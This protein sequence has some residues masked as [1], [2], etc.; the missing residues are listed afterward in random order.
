MR[1]CGRQALELQDWGNCR[2]SS[3]WWRDSLSQTRVTVLGV[4]LPVIPKSGCR[5]LAS[6]RPTGSPAASGRGS[7]WGWGSSPTHPER[8]LCRKGGWRGSV[9]LLGNLAWPSGPPAGP[10]A[11]AGRPW[12]LLGGPGQAGCLCCMSLSG[13]EVPGAADHS[14]GPC[15]H[16]SGLAWEPSPTGA[17][18]PHVGEEGGR[19]VGERRVRPR[20]PS[21][22]AGPGRPGVDPWVLRPVEPPARQGFGGGRSARKGSCYVRDQPE[23]APPSLTPSCP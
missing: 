9:Y 7:D 11:R 18:N 5:G 23:A 1:V 8:R 19:V 15:T 16:Q 22:G 20:I 4:S 10:G 17:S 21:R 2:L 6:T 3:R 14:R 12:G 13:E